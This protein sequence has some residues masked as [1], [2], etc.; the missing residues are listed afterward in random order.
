LG[1][2]LPNRREALHMLEEAGCSPE[3]IE[4][5]KDVASLALDIARACLRA[6]ARVDL[7]LIEVGALLHDIG[8]S[9]TH[10]IE[11]VFLGAELAEEMGLD[12]RLVRIV[13][14]HSCGV[15]P[16]LAEEMGLA[17]EACEPKTLE[18]KIIAYADKLVGGRRVL[19][20][21]E[22]LNKLVEELGPDHPA[23]KNLLKIR[24]ELLA[25]LGG[26]L[27]ACCRPGKSLRTT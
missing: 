2:R 26:E 8:R 15:S 13:L 11:H 19:A 4:H 1:R 20:F 5:C 17:P 16:G 25:L 14:T 18:E 3:V 24:G 10:S 6:G 12:E 9:M 21:E 27:D 23:V 7:R 22:A